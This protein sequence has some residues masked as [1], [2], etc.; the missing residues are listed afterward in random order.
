MGQCSFNQ[1]MMN[2][3][4]VKAK[5]KGWDNVL[6]TGRWSKGAGVTRMSRLSLHLSCLTGRKELVLSSLNG[7]K[8]PR[9]G[10]TIFPAITLQVPA[11]W[12]TGAEERSGS[13]PRA[14]T[15]WPEP[16]LRTR[17]FH[18]R[19]DWSDRTDRTNGKRPSKHY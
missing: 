15:F 4:S 1:E 17:A 7:S 5:G 3:G 16:V 13:D 19:T 2:R 6:L 9:R 18:S 10:R 12:P 11:L 14:G 8:G